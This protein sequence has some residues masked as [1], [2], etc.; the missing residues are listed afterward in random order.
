MRASAALGDI[1][2]LASAGRFTVV[3]TVMFLVMHV[4]A[5]LM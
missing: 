1:S 4:H 2:T 3:C 5:V